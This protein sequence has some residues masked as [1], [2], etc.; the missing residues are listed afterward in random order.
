MLLRHTP[1]GA[2][3]PAVIIL[4]GGGRGFH[5]DWAMKVFPM[6]NTSFMRV[7][8]D[9]PQHGDRG[10]PSSI[11]RQWLRDPVGEF[12][13]PI[14][15]RMRKELTSV[16]DYLQAREDVDPGR[17]GACGWSIGGTSVIL[18]MPRDKRIKAAAAI[19]AGQ[20]PRYML[21]DENR[22]E[23]QWPVQTPPTEKE[24]EWLTR[25]EDPENWAHSFYPTSLLLLH[26][27]EDRQVPACISRQLYDILRPHYQA[28]PSRLKLVEFPGAGHRPTAEMAQAVTGWFQQELL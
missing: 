17:V 13:A 9:L 10:D 20:T 23:L 7:Y 24:L 19:A 1:D 22:G 4:P 28:D 18:A 21:K 2:R 14:I 11:R 27:T 15:V 6:D 26:G 12:I 5:K 25:E 3:K 8:V 16:I